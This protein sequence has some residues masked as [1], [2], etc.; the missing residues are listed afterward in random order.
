MGVSER[1]TDPM[2]EFIMSLRAGK[3]LSNAKR[4]GESTLSTSIEEFTQT[5]SHVYSM[6]VKGNRKSCI[7]LNPC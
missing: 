7:E 2:K 1:M 3:V 4:D 5:L 6:D